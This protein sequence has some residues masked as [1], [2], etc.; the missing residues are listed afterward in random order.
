MVKLFRIAQLNARERG[1]SHLRFQ[2]EHCL[3][4]G[5]CLCGIVAEELEHLAYMFYVFVAN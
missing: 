1:L 5:A 4:F 3:C 2:R